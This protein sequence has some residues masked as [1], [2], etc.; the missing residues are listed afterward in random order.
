MEYAR[1]G[2]SG[3]EVSRVVLGCMSFGEPS[4]GTHAWSFGLDESRPFFRQALESGI[5]TFDTA[6]VYSLG[7]SEEITGKL[8]GEF[9]KRTGFDPKPFVS[10]S[11]VLKLPPPST[12]MRFRFNTLFGDNRATLPSSNSTSACPF[13]PVVMT[14]P[15]VNGMFSCAGSP[16]VWPAPKRSTWT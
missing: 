6:N 15:S 8:L 1:L 9:A 10:P 7:V 3:L 4:Q 11:S 13:S 5:T 12:V 14:C 2:Q 16:A